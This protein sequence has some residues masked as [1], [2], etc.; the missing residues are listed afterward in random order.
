MPE[1]LRDR[2][3]DAIVALGDPN[4]SLRAANP[5]NAVDAVLAAITAED[6]SAAYDAEITSRGIPPAPGDDLRAARLSLSAGTLARLRG[7]R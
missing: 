5:Y 1:T 7:A 2:A 4:S 6:L 3:R